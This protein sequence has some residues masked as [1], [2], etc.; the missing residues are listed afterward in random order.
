MSRNNLQQEAI[1][2]ELLKKTLHGWQPAF[3]IVESYE[4]ST[5]RLEHHF[6]I[7]RQELY[8]IK[9]KPHPWRSSILVFLHLGKNKWRVYSLNPIQIPR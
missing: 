3:P 6:G 7:S 4:W 1:Q 2:L 5:D 8:K 9:S